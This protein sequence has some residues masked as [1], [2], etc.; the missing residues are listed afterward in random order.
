MQG[1]ILWEKV[2]A[3]RYYIF[4]AKS[5]HADAGEESLDTRGRLDPQTFEGERGV[6]QMEYDCQENGRGLFSA[7][8]HRKTM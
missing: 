4:T 6:D 2:Y 1:R 5:I 3:D 8:P 7:C